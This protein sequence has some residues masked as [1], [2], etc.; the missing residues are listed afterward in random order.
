MLSNG[1]AGF[2]GRSGE[3]HQRKRRQGAPGRPNRAEGKTGKQALR[4]LK[5]QISDAIFACLQADARRA[6]NG[7]GG[8][9][10]NDSGSSA[11]GSHP[12][13]RLFGQATPGPATQPMT[14]AS[15]QPAPAG[16]SRLAAIPR[17]RA[18]G[19]RTGRGPA[20]QRRPQGVLDPA[21]REPIIPAAG[22][23]PRQQPKAAAQRTPPHTRPTRSP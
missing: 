23:R 14:P 6:A 7:P 22:K 13:H 16:L 15:G 3:T 8:Q 1:H 20:A 2:G 12:A 21:A 11:A 17:E 10:G 5:R 9:P 18:G 19:S 4:A